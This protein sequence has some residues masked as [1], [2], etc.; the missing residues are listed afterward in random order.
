MSEHAVPA[1]ID[2]CGHR[3]GCPRYG[4]VPEADTGSGFV[5]LFCGCHDN[6]EPEVLA[7]G[8]DIAWPAGW[9]QQRA[10][11]WRIKNGLAAPSEPGAGP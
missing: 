5:D 1:G 11:E 6:A 2:N 10:A 3:P 9:N 7:N 4:E 8:T